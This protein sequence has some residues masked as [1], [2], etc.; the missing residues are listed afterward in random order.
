MSDNAPAL[1][2]FQLVEATLAERGQTKTWLS[3][4]SGV[5]RT[6]LN[7]WRTKPRSPQASS[8]L[9]VADTLGIDRQKALRLAGLP[10]NP[11]TADDLANL[12]DLPTG[13]LVERLHQIG[14]ELARRA[15]D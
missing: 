5:T 8:V 3:Q 11:A 10:A 13:V 12:A 9:A 2:F 14:D 4:R 7:N 6:T 1:P 15:K